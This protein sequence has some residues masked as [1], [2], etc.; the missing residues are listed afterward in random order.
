[1]VIYLSTKITWTIEIMLN[2]QDRSLYSIERYVTMSRVILMN[3]HDVIYFSIC[4]KIPSIS[5]FN[6]F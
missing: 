5:T 1:M 4:K 3:C 6:L 2:L